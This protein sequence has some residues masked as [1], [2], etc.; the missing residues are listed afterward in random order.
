MRFHVLSDI[1][2]EFY[3]EYPGIAAF[4]PSHPPGH[5]RFDALLLCGDLG[6]PGSAAY[7][8]F[9]ADCV[10]ALGSPLVFVIL[11]NHEA[12]GRSL[13]DALALARRAC[14]AAGARLLEC[15]SADLPGTDLRVAGTTLW[16][17]IAPRHA[18]EIRA[19]VRDFSA[20]EGWGVADHI[21]A[22][23]RCSAWLRAEI[24]M[25]EAEGRRLVVMTHH[26]PLL[27]LG[28]PK[29]ARSSIQSAFASDLRALVGKVALWAYGHDHFSAWEVVGG[30]IVISNQA[31]YPG[32]A[33]PPG[34]HLLFEPVRV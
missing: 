8:R 4:L 12:Y 16:S 30:A 17:D 25:A 3:D 22:F 14:A 9:L 7:A 31:G 6:D 28:D 10:A 2:L 23:R 19:C 29:H 26:A 21:D 13:A 1:H 33:A 20:I 34:A 15:E 18:P 32:E 24:A 5:A 11:G 27:S